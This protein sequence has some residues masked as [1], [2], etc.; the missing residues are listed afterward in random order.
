MLATLVQ[1]SVSTLLWSIHGKALHQGHLMIGHLVVVPLEALL[2]I[3]DAPVDWCWASLWSAKSG[4]LDPVLCSWF[5][6]VVS[7]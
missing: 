7:P 1:P 6:T 3:E 5:G 2:L 4:M